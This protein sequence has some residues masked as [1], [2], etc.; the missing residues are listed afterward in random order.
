MRATADRQD[1]PVGLRGIAAPPAV[2]LWLTLVTLTLFGFLSG[3][4][5][6]TRT[7]PVVVAWLLAAAVLVWFVPGQRRPSRL[8][9]RR[10]R[11]PRCLHSVGR[12]L[13]PVV[14]RS[15]PFV[16]GVRLRRLLPGARRLDR[17]PADGAARAAP[18]RLRLPRG[19]HG[20]RPVRL[21]R[22]SVARS[23]D[24]R[25]H[26]REAGQPGRLLERARSAHGHGPAGRAVPGR[27]ARDTGRVARRGGR[28]AGAYRLH[29]RLLLLARRG[30]RP[31][32]VR[33]GV[34]RRGRPPPG[35]RAVAGGG[36]PPRG[37]RPV[38]APRARHALLGDGRRCAAHGTGSHPAALV[39]GGH[40]RRR[41]AA[42]R[43]GSRA[44]RRR[45]AAPPQ[46]RGG[47]GRPRRGGRRLDRRH[48]ALRG[49]AGRDYMAARPLRRDRE[50]QRHT[51]DRGLR[52]TAS[53]AEHRPSA[54]LEGGAAAVPRRAG[55]G[56]RGRHLPLLALP[57]PDDWGSR[58]ARPQPVAER[59]QRTGLA[60][61]P[62]LRG[63]DGAAPCGRLPPPRA[64]SP[65]RRARHRGRPSGG[66]ARLR[67]PHV[68]GL[69]L[70]HGRRHDGALPRRGR[71]GRVSHGTRRCRIRRPQRGAESDRRGRR[72]R[73]D[74]SPATGRRRERRRA[75]R[76]DASRREACVPPGG[77][78]PVPRGRWRAVCWSSRRS[79]GCCRTSPTAR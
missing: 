68:V 7:A 67:G 13:D 50:R 70:G 5:I 35:Q 59:P 24:T 54:H 45:L 46:H 34:L 2:V 39:A 41:P 42:D 43:S 15:R 77:P 31:A 22:K 40:R 61:T 6:V 33:G 62:Q 1:G 58:E 32:R 36:R 75:A 57:L 48:L 69:G 71:R 60:W 27:P 51:G 44:P 65:R 47:R 72:G 53:L 63:R 49:A 56:H 11:R 30:A 26:V 37:L 18:G 16:G 29:V 66:R 25:P 38:A 10:A 23:G 52:G 78:R 76:R 14:V 20:D 73:S 4:Y 74:G 12:A 19:G 17:A 21:R 55:R 64:R 79:A 8:V 28:R 3:G 9:P